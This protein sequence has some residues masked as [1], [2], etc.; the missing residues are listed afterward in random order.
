MI[1]L[2]LPIDCMNYTQVIDSCIN[3]MGKN[4]I[5]RIKLETN[6]YDLI[7]IS[8]LYM[9]WG[10]SNELFK[11][12][13]LH[14]TQPINMRNCCINYNQ[15][16]DDMIKIYTTYFVKNR[17]GGFYDKIINNAKNPNIQCP[18][19]GGINSPNELDHFLPKRSFSYYAIFPYN[20]IPIC[21]DCNQIY[22]R[23]FYPKDKNRQLIHPYLDNEQVFNEKWLYARCIIDSSLDLGIEEKLSVEFYVNTPSNWEE[24]KKE[25]VK[26]HFRQF[27]L[28]ERFAIHSV[29]SLKTLLDHIKW[30]KSANQAMQTVEG[31]IDSVIDSEKLPNSWK[32]ALFEA[33]K[34]ELPTIWSSI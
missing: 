1:K 21:K 30:F 20:L 9:K 32:K 2:D 7:K 18:F 17:C 31:F 4:N 22:K 12:L 33:V 27:K 34:K 23:E 5:L 10:K 15:D 14:N 11:C 16:T 13:R 24:D 6:K 19:C 28:A 25:K 29:S 8:K 26:L 3:K